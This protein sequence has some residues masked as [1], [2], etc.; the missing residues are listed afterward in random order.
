M[1]PDR[2]RGSTLGKAS[3]V[4]PRIHHIQYMKKYHW[5]GNIQHSCDASIL[6]HLSHKQLK[7]GGQD[8]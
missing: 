1:N 3:C 6:N 5:G 2:R 7:A 4:F 8:S